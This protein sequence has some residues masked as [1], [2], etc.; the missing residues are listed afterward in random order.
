MRRGT[1]HCYRMRRQFTAKFLGISLLFIALTV[2][3]NLLLEQMGVSK[4]I[5]RNPFHALAAIAALC[6]I[7]SSAVF[8]YLA[9]K[10]FK[11]MED[12]N[13]A[14]CEVAKGNYEVQIRY[15]G[16]VQELEQIISSFNNMVHELSSVEMIRNDFITNVSHE[17]KTPLSSVTGYVTL[18]QD[19]ELSEEERSEYIQK[20]FFNIEKLN[21]LTE[22]ILRLSR[23][24]HQTYLAPAVTYRLDEQIREAIVLLEPKWSS[25][26]L[27][28]DL[29]LGEITYTGQR[30]LLF[31]VWTNLLGNAIKFSHKGGC[32]TVSLKQRGDSIEALFS[33]DGIGMTTETMAHIFD[34]FYQGDTSRRSQGNGL[35]LALCKEILERVGGKIYVTSQPDQGSVFMVQLPCTPLTNKR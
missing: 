20:V 12:M 29:D 34:K 1:H 3:I 22:N 14:F 5:V 30:A 35:G 25:R 10:V 7:L 27:E 24:E 23:L 13:H 26:Q 32:I 15:D 4:Q 17:F 9:Q 6:F 19:P 31:Q 2:G 16:S 8:Y 33:D 18:L 21:D 11:P 28:F